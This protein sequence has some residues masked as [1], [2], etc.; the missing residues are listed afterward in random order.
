MPNNFEVSLGIDIDG[1]NSIFPIGSIAMIFIPSTSNPAVKSGWIECNGSELS[2]TTYEKLFNVIG[3]TYGETNGSGGVGTSHFK[4]PTLIQNLSQTV[5]AIYPSGSNTIFSNNFHSHSSFNSTVT[6]PDAGTNHT[7]TNLTW[8]INQAPGN[9]AND[10]SYH[11]H[12]GNGAAIGANGGNPTN[13]ANKTGNARVNMAGAGHNHSTT[14]S[15]YSYVAGWR[16]GHGHT[17]VVF[18]DTYQTHKHTSSVSSIIQDVDA[19]LPTPNSRI[20]KYIMRV[21]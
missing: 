1:K 18:N 6:V 5:P 4:I 2:K 21:E 10:F 14:S 12:S 9:A 17:G 7:R 16:H 13:V 19:S 20:V 15:G 11:D 8:N 3:I